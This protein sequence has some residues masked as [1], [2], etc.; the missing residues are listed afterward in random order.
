MS[1]HAD[2]HEEIASLKTKLVRSTGILVVRQVVLRTIGFLGNV[3]LAR[4]LAPEEFGIFAVA[5]FVVAFFTLI[6]EVGLGAALIQRKGEL[7]EEEIQTTFTIQQGFF[8]VLFLLIYLIAPQ[9]L[10]FYPDL[11]QGSE[12]LVRALALSLL[13]TSL[14]TVPTILLERELAYDKIARIEV[15][16]VLTYQVIAVARAVM[17]RGRG[18]LVTAAI[19]R[20]VAGVIMVFIYVKW[21]PSFHIDNG[22][23]RR[24]LGFG[25][26]YQLSNFIYLGADAVVPVF[27][28]MV[29]GS[30]AVGFLTW[31]KAFSHIPLFITSSFSRAAFP[32]FSKLQ[33]NKD[34]L[35]ESI[36]KAIDR[37][38]LV[39]VPLAVLM[40]ALGP[41]LVRVIYTGKW[42]PGINAY[43]LYLCVPLVAGLSGPLYTA[44]LALGKS[45]IILA[46]SI[47]L[48]VLEWAFGVPL[49]LKYGF[50]GIP[51]GHAIILVILCILYLK[52]LKK[53]GVALTLTDF[54]YRNLVLALFVGIIIFKI[55]SYLPVTIIVIVGLFLVGLI[56]YTALIYIFCRQQFNEVYELV[57]IKILGIQP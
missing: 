33:E 36:V 31:S 12:W 52:V 5:A 18:A 13:I 48:T 55:K 53:H 45:Q 25:V 49:V 15:A 57:K 16:E 50:M 10:G 19:L 8:T 42:L 1:I 56:L 17:G 4:I 40:A 34:A 43:Y 21:K 26:P 46:I 37:L 38:N 7:T 35:K 11:P 39:M 32:A 27:V 3:I 47:T 9:I 29:K 20:G 2:N 41:E 24:L 14:R 44:I 51:L 30:S 28:A 23:A 22:A 54:R 6:G